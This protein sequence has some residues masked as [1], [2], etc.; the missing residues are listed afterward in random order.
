MSEL[1][2][3][4]YQ[5]WACHHVLEAFKAGKKRVALCMA[6]G[7]GK[8]KLALW[9]MQYA[10]QNNRKVLF[11]GNRR[12]LVNQAADDAE[13]NEIPYG[14][15][16]ADVMQGDYGSTNQ[17]ASLQTLESRHM[18]DKWSNIATGAGLPEADLV[19]HDELH[20][21]L[22]SVQQLMRFYPNSKLLGL[23]ATPVGADGAAV[24]PSPYEFLIEPIKNSQLIAQNYLLPTKVYAPS[25]PHL[26]GVKIVKQGEYNQKALGKRVHE[27][28]VFGD[29]LKEWEP[30][31]DRATVCFVPG[32]AFGHDLV[33]QFR[34]ALGDE[35][36]HMIEAKTKHDEREEIFRKITNSEASILVSVDVLRE[37]WDMPVVSCAIDLQ[38]N[39]QLRSYWQ[40][41]GRIKRPFAEQRHAVYLDFAGNYWKFPHPDEDPSW[42]QGGEGETTQEIIE[43]KRKEKV[44]AQPIMCP[45]CS[46]VRAKGPT[47]PNCGR[48]S[49]E[50]I[51]RIR[52]GNGKL[53]EVPA[54]AR[55][56]REKSAE[57]RLFAKW[58]SK[59]FAAFYSGMTYGQAAH[60]FSRETGSYPRDG[61]PGTFG[62]GSL[63]WK[64]RP[65]VDHS[66]GTLYSELKRFQEQIQQ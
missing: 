7:S 65:S 46:C 29:V 56:A 12:L 33:R 49:G 44:E 13:S 39:N 61:W 28:T 47:C 43:R 57:E 10:S 17:I 35:S 60:L 25:E 15:I 36:T 52:M 23:S 20:S 40:K 58:Q 63:D 32:V 30:Y 62:P 50:T 21:S 27:C 42:P 24:V 26:E 34:N 22:D 51:R 2:L 54:I 14:V 1:V 11:V 6:T 55:K 53:V 37:G 18:Y 64:R 66:K 59:L 38:P 9:F 8:R 45:N 19:I 48:S 41:I 31:R 3:R 16:M 4:P 5:Q